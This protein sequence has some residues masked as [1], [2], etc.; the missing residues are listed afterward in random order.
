VSIYQ[1]VVAG[2]YDCPDQPGIW[3]FMMEI[4][5]SLEGFLAERSTANR[6]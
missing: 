1:L 5:F 3:T 6:E 4:G 2:T